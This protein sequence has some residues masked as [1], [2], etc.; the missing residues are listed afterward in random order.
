LIIK[1]RKCDHYNQEG[2]KMKIAKMKTTVLSIPGTVP[3]QAIDHDVSVRS[4]RANPVIVQ[5]IT[6]D[7]LDAFGLAFSLD[8]MHLKGLKGSIDDLEDLII[9]QDVFRWAEAWD[10]IFNYLALG[11]QGGHGM[12]ALS[13]ID[14]AL[15]ALQAKALGLPLSRL[16]GGFREEVPVYASN[17]LFRNWKLDDLQKD[18]ASLVGQ[19]FNALKM[20]VGG[21]S[22]KDDLERVKV[23]R[24]AVGNDV[25]IMVDALW[26]WT[27]PET[28]R[29]GRELEQYNVYWLE[30]PIGAYG[31]RGLVEDVEAQ[32]HITRSLDTPITIG[33]NLSTKYGFRRLLENRAADILNVDIVRVGGI[34]EW[35]KVATLAQA[36]NIP[37]VSH[38]IHEISIHVVAAVPNGLIVEY[39]PW[40]DMIYQ[41]PP[42]IK[43]GNMKIRNEPGLGLELDA[44]MV[45]KYEI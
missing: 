40:W 18:A 25:K 41:E 39:M 29:I 9:G 32:A 24:E 11:H 45:K 4:G 36:W 17:W 34:T 16:L 7:G 2:E 37:I 8:D 38:L 42:V 15:W 14:T 21:R 27:V 26:S 3:I 10:K 35:V 5:L 12:S 43:N 22:L 30:D 28:L 44:D 33:E 20:K 19:G 31:G 1:K 6:D 23:V 13:A